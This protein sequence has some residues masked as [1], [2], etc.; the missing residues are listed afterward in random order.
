MA[1][2]KKPGKWRNRTL[3]VRAGTLRTPFQETS[4]ALFLTSGYAYEDAEE[5]EEPHHPADTASHRVTVATSPPSTPA[6]HGSYVS[7]AIGVLVRAEHRIAAC[8]LACHGVRGLACRSPSRADACQASRFARPGGEMTTSE[9]HGFPPSGSCAFFWSPQ[10][11]A[12][13]LA[14][15]LRAL[16]CPS[17]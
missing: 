8:H 4:E 13:L 14:N 9:L 12:Q 1:T 17:Q 10:R 2:N 16:Q 3:A 7:P 6:A 11:L 15:H 5:A